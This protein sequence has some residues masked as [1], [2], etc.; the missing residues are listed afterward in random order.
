LLN[1]HTP[2][3]VKIISQIIKKIAV[4]ISAGKNAL[5]FL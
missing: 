3:F 4:K 5:H 1:S 2:A